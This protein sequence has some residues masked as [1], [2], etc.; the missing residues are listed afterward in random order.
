MRMQYKWIKYFFLARS[1][2]FHFYQAAYL[3]KRQMTWSICSQLTLVCRLL[4]LSLMHL[5]RWSCTAISSPFVTKNVKY[6]D[7]KKT[8][9]FLKHFWAPF[10]SLSSAASAAEVNKKSP[11]VTVLLWCCFKMLHVC[12]L[13]ICAL[14]FFSMNIL[15]LSYGTNLHLILKHVIM[16]KK[17]YVW[18]TSQQAMW[19]EE[20]H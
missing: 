7:M 20:K 9:L 12:W 4:F 3:R 15:F 14:I 11:C 2:S 19:S 13:A 5:S 18:H 10:L 17:M 1:F 8:W 6:V 16:T